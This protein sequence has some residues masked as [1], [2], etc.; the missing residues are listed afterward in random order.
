MFWTAN[1]TIVRDASGSY[2]LTPD[3]VL[4]PSDY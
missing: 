4:T 3:G 1:H 2:R